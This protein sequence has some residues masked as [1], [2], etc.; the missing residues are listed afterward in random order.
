M[1]FESLSLIHEENYC[2]Y[3]FP[4]TLI[5]ATD[6]HTRGKKHQYST[7]ENIYLQ[8]KSQERKWGKKN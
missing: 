4:K 8:F 2:T 6:E 5:D 3:F 1:Y 7:C